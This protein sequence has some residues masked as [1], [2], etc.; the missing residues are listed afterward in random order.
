MS[1]RYNIILSKSPVDFIINTKV[2]F[3]YLSHILLDPLFFVHVY[4]C[5]LEDLSWMGSFTIFEKP[6]LLT[7]LLTTDLHFF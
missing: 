6:I 4:D 5:M 7:I 3:V 2:L 1:L